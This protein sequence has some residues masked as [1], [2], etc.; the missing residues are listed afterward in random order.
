MRY[1]R[2][3]TERFMPLLLDGGKGMLFMPVRH[4]KSL[5]SSVYTPAWYVM[6]N[7]TRNVI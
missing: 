3:V 5:Y 1:L 6:T 2:Y 7:Q 4:G